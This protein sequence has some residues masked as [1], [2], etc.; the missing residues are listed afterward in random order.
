MILWSTLWTWVKTEETRR[1]VTRPTIAHKYTTKSTQAARPVLLRIVLV[2][3]G[4]SQTRERKT[5]WSY[6][7]VTNP[8]WKLSNIIRR[9]SHK[10]FP[11]QNIWKV[12]I[13]I[14]I[15]SSTLTDLNPL[16]PQTYTPFQKWLLRR[17]LSCRANFA[18]KIPSTMTI[19]TKREL[20]IGNSLTREYWAFFHSLSG[21]KLKSWR[22]A[23]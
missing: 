17:S 6:L 23:L 18:A 11:I 22:I 13:Q 14:R 19:R 2:F 20:S 10:T 1:S 8:K 9:M 12:K 21:P 16:N 15:F 4:N 5:R 3:G 7:K